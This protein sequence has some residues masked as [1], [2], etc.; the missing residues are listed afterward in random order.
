MKKLISVLLALTAFL[1]VLSACGDDDG[2]VTLPPEDTGTPADNT[3]FFVYQGTTVRPG[4]LWSGKAGGL[5]AKLGEPVSSSSSPSCAFQGLD[6]TFTFPGFIVLTYP[7]NDNDYVL[8]IQFTDDSVTTP[9]G[10]RIGS[11]EADLTAAYGTGQKNGNA[12]VYTQGKTQIAA[13]VEN[14]TIKNLNYNYVEE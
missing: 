4:D 7:D 10:I 11:T 6:K 5:L 3:Y 14:G 2:V 12:V 1:F 9:A 13:V 8:N